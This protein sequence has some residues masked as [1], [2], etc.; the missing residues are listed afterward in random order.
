MGSFGARQLGAVSDHFQAVSRQCG[1]A[2]QA[3]EGG[4]IHV[5]T[6]IGASGSVD[7]AC[8]ETDDTNN[9][10]LRQCTVDAVRKLKLDPPAT[11][12]TVNFGTAILYPG[13]RIAGLCP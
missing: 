2:L 10:A 9:A 8:V 7:V 3:G 12:G 5:L 1:D 4:G 13:A 6:R 11:P